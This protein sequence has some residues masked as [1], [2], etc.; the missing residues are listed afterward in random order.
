MTKSHSLT[1]HAILAISP[2]Y[3]AWPAIASGPSHTKPAMFFFFFS[4][5]GGA[6]EWTRTVDLWWRKQ[7]HVM[8]A[9]AGHWCGQTS[10]GRREGT[11]G[12]VTSLSSDRRLTSASELSLTIGIRKKNSQIISFLIIQ[13]DSN[14]HEPKANHDEMT[15]NLCPYSDRNQN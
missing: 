10:D 6:Q 11:Q 7:I 3:C 12:L 13:S 5:L 15:V 1:T 4:A 8:L 9:T 14:C 2:F